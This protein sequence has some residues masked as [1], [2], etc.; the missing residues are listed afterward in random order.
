MNISALRATTSGTPTDADLI[1]LAKK[2]IAH[3]GL[4]DADDVVDACVVRQPK[5]YP[6]YD[7]AYRE[8]S[9]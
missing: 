1:A 4:I 6:V 8:M 2:E 9:R 5:A 7:D 3:I